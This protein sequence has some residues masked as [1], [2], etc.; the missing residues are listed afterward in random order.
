MERA[1][2]GARPVQEVPGFEDGARWYMAERG[3]AL[4][5]WTDEGMDAEAIGRH[6]VGESWF[7]RL[8][9]WAGYLRVVLLVGLAAGSAWFASRHVTA[10]SSAPH[11]VSTPGETQ[12]AVVQPMD[13]DGANATALQ[14][15]VHGDVR[16]PGLVTL[17]E[18]ARVR[19]AI[20]AAGGF[21]H[22]VDAEDVNQAALVWDGEEI[23]IP[24][25]TAGDA[26]S[27][28]QSGQSGV[29]DVGL[30]LAA[31]SSSGRDASPVSRDG[32]GERARKHALTAGQKININTADLETLE[33]LPGVGPKRAAAILAYREAHGP[34]PD[35]ASLRH[36]RG[37]GEK[38]LAKWKDLITF[39]TP[40]SASSV[41]RQAP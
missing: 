24:A 34:F 7:V 14:V 4:P 38:T 30:A 29:Q 37:I 19:D 33:T 28:P 27:Q 5:V 26:A 23:D 40:D 17:Q 3:G 25:A 16:H 41:S 36:V 31:A 15:D 35:L 9:A 20:R 11:S 32:A 1:Q 18:G 21:L 22:A 13:A 10:A 12:S 2:D 8:R 39:G 6:E